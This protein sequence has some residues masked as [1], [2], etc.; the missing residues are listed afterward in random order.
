MSSKFSMRDI[1]SRSLEG[2]GS[3]RKQQAS[4]R[5]IAQKE[6]KFEVRCWGAD[7][8]GIPI[9][10]DDVTEALVDAVVASVQSLAVGSFSIE[11]GSFTSSTFESAQLMVDGSEFVF[12]VNLLRPVLTTLAPYNSTRSHAPSDVSP[13]ITDSMTISTGQNQAGCEAP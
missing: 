2:N 5:A 1:Y 6:I 3:E 10:N 9:D 11:D 12:G 7:P 8:S 13:D 4:M